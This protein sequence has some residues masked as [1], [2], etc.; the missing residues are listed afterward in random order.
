LDPE[1]FFALLFRE[2]GGD[3]AM[4]APGCGLPLS[5]AGQCSQARQKGRAALQLGQR[6]L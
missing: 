4:I 5:G 2:R 3:L 1:A 6:R